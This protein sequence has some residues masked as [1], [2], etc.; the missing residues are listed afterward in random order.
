M[1]MQARNLDSHVRDQTSIPGDFRTGFDALHGSSVVGHHRVET[2]CEY[3]Y[4]R[5][6]LP[7]VHFSVVEENKGSRGQ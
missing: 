1:S 4:Q 7:T 5:T 3:I 2:A 6:H